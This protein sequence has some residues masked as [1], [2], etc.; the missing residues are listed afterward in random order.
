MSPLPSLPRTLA[1]G[2]AALIPVALLSEAVL[3]SSAPASA[4]EFKESVTMTTLMDAT[5]DHT[6]VRDAAVITGAGD[7]SPTGTVTF[8]IYGPGDA[9]CTQSPL[10]V[11]TAA[12]IPLAGQAP[13]SSTQSQFLAIAAPGTYRAIAS[14]SGD[15]TYQAQ[16]GL[17]NDP[18]ESITIAKATPTL[19]SQMSPSVQIG[20]ILQDTAYLAGGFAPTGQMSFSFYWPGDATCSTPPAL[21]T[22][23]PV[24]AG[25]TTSQS[26]QPT[27]PGTYRA[28]ASYSGDANNEAV[29]G[30][31]NDAGESANVTLA[32]PTIT[33]QMSPSVVLGGSIYDTATLHDGITPSGQITFTY[34]GPDDADCSGNAVFEYTVNVAAD[35]PSVSGGFTPQAAGVYRAIANY[36]GDANNNYASAQGVCNDPG[37]SVLVSKAPTQVSTELGSGDFV[38]IPMAD[39]AHVIATADVTGSMTFEIFGPNDATCSTAPVSVSTRPVTQLYDPNSGFDPVVSEEYIPVRPGT[40]R[41]VAHYSGDAN[42]LPSSGVCGESYETIDVASARP[43]FDTEM[44]AVN[45]SAIVDTLEFG[46]GY[47]MTGTIAFSIYGPGD[48]TCTQAPVWVSTV[49]VNG[50]AVYTSAPYQPTESGTYRAIAVYSGDDGNLPAS[51]ACNDDGESIAVL[52]PLTPSNP[53]VSVSSALPVPPAAALASTGPGASPLRSGVLGGSALV[54]GAALLVLGSIRRRATI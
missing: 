24:L 33:S 7:L 52:V 40:Y 36:S 5:S 45:G 9:N 39:Y 16:V 44:T 11:D 47:A 50:Y 31:C 6:G 34:F 17:C 18:G 1:R 12:L 42:N 20:G 25:G 15:A 3:G 49:P 21:T 19:S 13:I 46:E 54:L 51:G 2:A 29:S 48:A 8:L 26:L 35:G 30:L 32:E 22:T 10:L 27:A 28:I 53:Q 43:L 38:G 14:Y 37:E 41:A 4:T 23:S